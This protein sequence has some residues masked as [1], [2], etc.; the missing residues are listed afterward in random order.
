MPVIVDCSKKR[1]NKKGVLVA[2]V[3]KKYFTKHHKKHRRQVNEIQ[4]KYQSHGNKKI[5][6]QMREAAKKKKKEIIATDVS[7]TPVVFPPTKT[8]TKK[9]IQPTLINS[10]PIQQAPVFGNTG[11]TAG[12]KRMQNTINRMEKHYSNPAHN[13]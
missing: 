2:T 12:Q 10:A 11:Q 8:K 7:Q 5:Y 13:Y 1:K 9:R 3:C 4:G 6:R